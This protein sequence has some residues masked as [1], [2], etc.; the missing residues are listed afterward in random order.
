MQRSVGTPG[1]PERLKATLKSWAY[2]IPATIFIQIGAALSSPPGL[3][4]VFW[5]LSF[6]FIIIAGFVWLKAFSD[7]NVLVLP[8]YRSGSSRLIHFAGGIVM[9]IAIMILSSAGP[10]ALLSPIVL[11]T[12]V[13]V[14]PGLLAWMMPDKDIPAT[15][16]K[17]M[18]SKFI[19]LFLLGAL[20]V[21]TSFLAGPVVV[22]FVKSSY[23]MLMTVFLGSAVNL[24]FAADLW[25]AAYARTTKTFTFVAAALVIIS[26]I[27]TIAFKII[28]A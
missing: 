21:F 11:V 24:S 13:M 23:I 4:A 26:F 2:L 27:L 8:Q 14:W 10:G 19:C 22:H 1:S 6:V 9:L 20:A 18:S 15:A 5:L 7:Y 3:T 16:E 12:T 25:Q 28:N 17:G